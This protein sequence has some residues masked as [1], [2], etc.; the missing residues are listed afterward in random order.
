MNMTNLE[1]EELKKCPICCK[2]DNESTGITTGTLDIAK[3]YFFRCDD[4]L[5]GL[6]RLDSD[7]YP[8]LPIPLKDLGFTDLSRQE[9]EHKI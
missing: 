3:N 9:D 4:C 7:I 2:V 5:V 1:Q 6:K 8:N